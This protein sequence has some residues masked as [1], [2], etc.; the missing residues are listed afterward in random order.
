MKV[1]RVFAW[2]LALIMTFSINVPAGDFVP[3]GIAARAETA[4]L[5]EETAVVEELAHAPEP[6]PA[7][8]PDSAEEPTPAPEPAPVTAPALAEEPAPAPEPTATEKPAAAE[9]PTAAQ[10]PAA[11]THAPTPTPTQAPTPTTTPTLT[12]T[13]T[14][15][16]T[17]TYTPMV[18]PTSTTT[19][20]PTTTPAA[21]A[22][23][24]PAATAA[25]T[26]SP[27]PTVENAVFESGYAH[28]DREERVYASPSGSSEVLGV[29]ARD[30]IVYVVEPASERWM[31]VV[32]AFEHEGEQIEEGY[33]REE[34]LTSEADQAAAAAA[35]EAGR[36][37]AC[38]AYSVPLP[39][40][41]FARPSAEAD[42]DGDAAQDGGQ[43]PAMGEAAVQEEINREGTI[44]KNSVNLRTGPSKSYDTGWWNEPL[45]SARKS[46]RQIR[47]P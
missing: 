38:G 18:A 30:A 9:E 19:P 2:L 28:V 6:A 3:G 42:G 24:T 27:S 31:N 10:E 26:P 1:K 7:A 22:T 15:T 23:P 11:P 47:S 43:G 25:P 8:E 17:Q 41:S 14:V 34:S 36:Y 29:L 45:A 13:P 44:S 32:F 4:I 37:V 5:A 12:P 39:L 35:I 20:T 21:T 40:V 16:A 33:L 46:I